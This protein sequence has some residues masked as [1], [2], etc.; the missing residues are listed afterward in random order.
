MKFI[1]APFKLDSLGHH[2]FADFEVDIRLVGLA[3]LKTSGDAVHLAVFDKIC[4]RLM[5]TERYTTSHTLLPH[6]QNPIV[7]A[8]TSLNTRFTA[9][10]HF[11]NFGRMDF[12]YLTTE[13]IGGFIG[14]MLGVFAQ[15]GKGYAEYDWM[16]YE[17]E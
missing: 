17:G 3:E 9:Y 14:V 5:E 1:L 11:L 6:V 10:R 7:I 15:G 12:R 8:G 4:P 13:V 16:E 2:I